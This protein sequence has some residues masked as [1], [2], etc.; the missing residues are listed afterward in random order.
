M[1]YINPVVAQ[2]SHMSVPALVAGVGGWE[3]AVA[4]GPEMLERTTPTAQ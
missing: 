2:S 1:L 4:L 3:D